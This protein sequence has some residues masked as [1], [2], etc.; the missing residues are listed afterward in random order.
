LCSH[1]LPFLLCFSHHTEFTWGR[2]RPVKDLNFAIELAAEKGTPV[3]TAVAAKAV[4]DKAA[5]A[6]GDE[7]FAAVAEALR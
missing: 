2:L 4:F 7:D 5:V 1:A 3:P 6:H